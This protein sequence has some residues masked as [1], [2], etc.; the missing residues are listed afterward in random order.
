M[1]AGRLARLLEALA[2]GFALVLQIPAG[3]AGRIGR[4]I[5]LLA[6]VLGSFGGLELVPV[7]R[8]ARCC[9]A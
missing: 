7:L 9:H 4:A 2:A 3:L 5:G 1:D 6:D 8:S